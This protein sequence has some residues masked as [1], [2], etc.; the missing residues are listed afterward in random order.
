[1]SFRIFLAFVF[2]F[3][4]ISRLSAQPDQY[5]FIR[6]DND[7]GLSNNQINC[8]LEDNQ[9]FMWFGTM[10]GLN[11]YDGNAFKTFRHDVRHATS[12]R[13]NYINAIY[14]GPEE[15]LWV[16]TRGGLTIYDPLT[17]SFFPSTT[18]WLQKYALPDSGITKVVKDKIGDYWFVHATKGLFKYSPQTKVT[19]NLT[20]SL[21]AGSVSDFV[22]DK[23]NDYWLI[24]R[25]GTL[26]KR[27]GKNWQVLFRNRHLGQQQVANRQGFHLFADNSNDLWIYQ[28]DVPAGIFCFNSTTKVFQHYHRDSEK[29]KLNNDLVRSVIQNSDGK[30]WV[31]TDHGGVNIIDKKN[32]TIAY[33]LQNSDDESSI[34]QN[35]IYSLYRNKANIIWVGTYKSG[36]SYYHPNNIKFPVYRYQATNP[37]SLPYNDI[38]R[39]VED[40]R[41]N[42]YMG[43]NG[44][45]LLYF[46]RKNNRFQQFQ[47]DPKNSNSLSNNVIVGLYLDK[48]QNLWIG[49]YYGGLDKFDGKTFTHY[50]HNPKD[51]NSISDDRVWEIFEDSR[52]NLWVGTLGGG[53]ELLDRKNETFRH[54]RMGQPKSVHSDFISSIIEDK[55]GNLWI[56]TAY[57]V[58]KLDRKTG[59]FIHYVN[60]NHSATG[61]SN[62]NIITVMEDSRGLIWMGTN[63]GL[64]IF[65]K[66]KNAFRSFRKEDGL[67]DNSI[68]GIVE[69]N[70]HTV[71][72]ATQNGISNVTVKQNSAATSFTLHFKNYDVSDGLQEKAFNNNAFL[73]TRSGDLLFGGS[74]G[75]NIFHPGKLEVNK[76]IP[77]V[78]LTDFQ[79]FNQFVEAGDSL[80]GR[81]LLTK[82]INEVKEITLRH[83]ENMFSIAF[84][85]LNFLQPE[86]N[87]YAYKLEGFNDQWLSVD[88]QV[89]KA[90]FTNLDPGTYIFRVKA[91]NND[92]L[93][94][95]TGAALRITILPPFWKT[96]LAFAF[97]I[98]LFLA[99]LWLAR[100]IVQTQ[101]RLKYKLVQEREEAQRRQELDTLK[102]RFFT[103]ISHEFRTPLTL[104]L[105]PL[106]KMLKEATAD[107]NKITQLKLIYR[108]ARRLLNLVNQLLDFRKM[109]VQEIVLHPSQIDVIPFIREIAFSFSDISE[110][111]NIQFT[112][113]TGMEHLVTNIDQDKMEKILFNLLSNAFKFTP[114]GGK[115]SVEVS[116]ADFN[117]DPDRKNLVIQVKDTGIGIPP[118]D[119]ENVFKRFF[120]SD[121]P[122]SMVNQGSGIGLAITKEFVKLH[123]GEITIQSAPGAGTCF[124]IML[125]VVQE[126]FTPVNGNVVTSEIQTLTTGISEVK[127]N[128]TKNFGKK[129]VILLVE[130]NEDFRFYLKDNLSVFYQVVEAANGKQGWQQ[131]VTLAP[132]LIVSDILMPEMDGITFSR[133][134]KKDPRTAGIPVILLTA[135]ATEEQ[136]LL[137]YETGASDYITK[138]FNFE[139]LLSRIKYLIAQQ[140]AF[141]TAL[142]HKMEV[143][144][145]DIVITPLDEK[146]I[147]KAIAFTEQNIANPDFSVEEL[148]RE[149]G[150]SRVYLYKKLLAITGKAPLEFIRTVRL[151][152]AAQLLTESQLTVAE[153]AYEVG[154]NN[155]KYFTKY[156]KQEFNE[157]PSAYATGKRVKV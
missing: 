83:H 130:D 91:S 120:Q 88:N 56:G 102:I 79:I 133:K 72:L 95:A 115:V 29:F 64:N 20:E 143:K 126:V 41:G 19:Q 65:D 105:S 62:N 103:N 70:Q 154:F 111:K 98:L 136:R 51:P 32:N 132:D 38:N 50:Q 31:G 81:V 99:A 89:R 53:L 44:G 59:E 97:Y 156:F 3:F 118:E 37:N 135:N 127:V 90:T 71:W 49:T 106:E 150:M 24:Y 137:G 153:V 84:A 124:T 18:R 149:L 30:I 139:I 9:G 40:A 113:Q 76:R 129:P 117:N 5:K 55:A 125:P 68:Q 54:Y 61:L 35:S 141:R 36:L 42:I 77:P 14:A 39:L 12:L 142:Q 112:F 101:E 96:N 80:N 28:E 27:S 58:D 151:K 94:N 104:I 67:P 52:N 152:R 34:S 119:Q 121:I 11:R 147:Q 47:H 128:G 110:N 8:I 33:L 48:K 155:P 100:K 75:F 87:K 157:L 15:K 17:E 63:E 146:L 74:N 93:W 85:A 2:L 57:G 145:Q 78:V 46:D 16:V 144:P 22:Q 148:S 7:K 21:H 66:K 73:K 134:L 13:D 6:I 86:K 1:M 109:E 25:D 26:E 10:T 138:P 122:G 69:D 116:V 131:A 45:G 82:N 123:Q 114:E 108:N 60:S 23:S 43:T 140:V 4:T 92:G 107:G